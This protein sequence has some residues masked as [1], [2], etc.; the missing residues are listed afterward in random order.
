MLTITA[1]GIVF[2]KIR[3]LNQV[4]LTKKKRKKKRSEFNF[5]SKKKIIIFNRMV[6]LSVQWGKSKNDV[7]FF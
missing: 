6:Q 1:G 7:P 5:S 4:F 3:L 2:R